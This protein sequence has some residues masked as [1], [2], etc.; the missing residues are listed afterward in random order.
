M[1][2]FRCTRC[3][4]PSTKPDLHFSSDGLCSA[5]QAFDKRSS[6]DWG[7]RARDFLEL[8]RA[9]PGKTHDVI[10]AC[11]GG[12]DSTAQIL[13]CLEL[14]LRP[15]AVTATTDHLSGLGRRN[16][17]NISNLCDHIEITPHKPTR[18]KIAK[19]A[20]QEIGDVSWCE[21]QLIWSVPAREALAR[22]I[23]IVIYGECPQAE[24]GA[25][26]AGTDE[27]IQLTKS[28]VD[29]FG[30]L[31]GLRLDD[32]A[33]ILEIPERHLE[34]YRYPKGEVKALWLGQFF[35]WDGYRNAKIARD[36]GFEWSA[37]E[38]EGTGFRYENLD[39]CQTGLRDYLRWLKRGYGRSCDMLSFH[40]RRGRIERNIAARM[41][42]DLE[43]R[44]PGTYLGTPLAEI[45]K[46]I[47]MT[48]AEFEAVCRRFRNKE[49]VE[50]ASQSASYR[51]FFGETTGASKDN[52]SITAAA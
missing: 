35:E 17:D 40:I 34:I 52:G 14:G 24:M 33:E 31:L 26:P 36:H 13:K 42:M 15:L 1:N 46:N 21:H 32:V 9:Q 25:G 2:L 41:A 6:I 27:A 23:P 16:L 44:W 48:M 49:V 12:K 8:V 4:Y 3:L 43:G 28:W 45:L 39:N 5:C 50:W 22:E 30:G 37:V 18:R 51:S 7:L 29:E 38:V 19:F 11:S 10:V 47:D 20:L